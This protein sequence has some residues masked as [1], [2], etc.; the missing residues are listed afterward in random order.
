M[1][2]RRILYVCTL[3]EREDGFSHL[4]YSLKRSLAVCSVA[5]GTTWT[6]NFCNTPWKSCSR[7]CFRF[8]WEIF[9]ESSIAQRAER[10]SWIKTICTERQTWMMITRDV[11]QF[12]FVTWCCLW[13]FFYNSKISCFIPYTIVR[14]R[15]CRNPLKVVFWILN[16]VVGNGI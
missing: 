4:S 10:T 13:L 11:V 6:G 12:F 14:K 15:V 2:I 16:S 3:N 5:S 7:L 9:P 8:S 1:H